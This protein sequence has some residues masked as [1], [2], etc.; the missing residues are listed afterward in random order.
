MRRWHTAVAGLLAV[1]AFLTVPVGTAPSQPRVERW[2]QAQ[3]W[4]RVYYRVCADRP[5]CYYATYRNCHR[6]Q[7]VVDYL[8]ITGCEAYYQ[9]IAAVAGA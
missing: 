6:A 3:C 8:H 7:L 1:V 2:C 9:Q 5:W 4:Y